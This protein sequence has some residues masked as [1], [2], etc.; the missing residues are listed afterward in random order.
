MGQ[1]GFFDANDRLEALSAKGDALEPID[2]QRPLKTG[3]RVPH[4]CGTV[5]RSGISQDS[6]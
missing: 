2:A 5:T 3:P 6:T 1:F 4:G